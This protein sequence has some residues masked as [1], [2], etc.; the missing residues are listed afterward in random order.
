MYRRQCAVPFNDYSAATTSDF[1]LQ[2]NV[3]TITIN[4]FW[5]HFKMVDYDKRMETGFTSGMGDSIGLQHCTA[6][7]V[8]PLAEL[9]N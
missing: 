5:K 8:M 1:Y 7:C 4:S 2:N 3:Y 6:A 9:I